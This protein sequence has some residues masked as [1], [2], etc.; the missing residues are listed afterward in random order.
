MARRIRDQSLESR[1][2]RRKLKVSGK[3]YWR[4][5]GL[6]LHLGYRKGERG[7][8]WCVRRY[9][10][11]QTYQ[12]DTIA[13]ADDLLDADGVGVL[14]FW[15]AQEQARTMREPTR[16]TGAYTIK[17]AID[18]YLLH[19][20]GRAT[21][22]ATSRTLR[23]HV[24]LDLAS[25]PVA[26]LTADELRKW[27]RGIAKQEARQRTSPGKPQNY[28][29][30]AGEEGER[31]RKA[32]A[33]N[34]LSH[35][36]AALNYAWREGKADL[37]AWQRVKPFKGVAIPRARYLSIAECQ[38]LINASDPD[39]RVLVRAALETGARYQELARLRVVD[40]N[41]DAGTLHIRK[42]KT[43]KDRHVIL[44]EDGQAFF[45]ALAAGR[46]GSAALLGKEWKPAYQSR[47]MEKACKRAGIEP[48]APFHSTRHTWASHAVM[49]GVPLIVVAKNLGHADTRMV[50]RAYGHL[51][52]GYIADAIR[53]GAPRFGPV[54][55]NVRA[56]K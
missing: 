43:N 19:L 31:K 53:A 21:H 39:F 44:T 37:G 47:P 51:D 46:A 36:K 9:L 5:I 40:F 54:E 1:E 26:D 4:S 29:A 35:M 50:E 3:P 22:Y 52:K 32:T 16:R 8:K 38:R 2:A 28:R 25:R 23:A 10:G 41:A 15:Q 30:T 17:D 49:N 33:N 42:S 6:G 18:D 56:I 11:K 24:S 27:H 55:G 13:I 20:E 48:P 7:G 12:V 34:V 45:A 14:D